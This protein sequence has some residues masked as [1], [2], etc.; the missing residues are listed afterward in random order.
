MAT[1]YASSGRRRKPSGNRKLDL[2]AVGLARSRNPQI[3]ERAAR[4]FANP[5][6]D[7]AVRS[8]AQLVDDKARLGPTVHKDAHFRPRDDDTHVKPLVA[9]R[10][11]NHRALVSAW[12]FRPQLLPGPGRLGDVLHGVAVARR[13]GRAKIEWPEIDGVVGLRVEDTKRDAE[14]AALNGLAPPQD[15]ELDHAISKVKTIQPHEAHARPFAEL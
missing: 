5:H 8:L 10:L 9:V 12:M 1:S 4:A 14:K 15:V 2:L 3:G 13:V 7:C 11:G 6:A